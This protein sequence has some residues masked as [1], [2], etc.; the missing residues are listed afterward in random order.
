VLRIIWEL[1]GGPRGFRETQGLC[2]QMSPNT[3]FTR[4]S[5]LKAAGIAAHD[6]D[7]DGAPTRLGRQ[8]GPALTALNTWASTWERELADRESAN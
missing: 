1:R 5:E 6:A 2:D 3:L 7:G 8:L 4:L